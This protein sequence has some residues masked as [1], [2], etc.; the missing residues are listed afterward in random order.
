MY[1]VKTYKSGGEDYD[2]RQRTWALFKCG[3]CNK[4]NVIDIT[5]IK[6]TFDFS[7]ER[8]CE[9]CGMINSEDKILNMKAQLNKL[10]V[11]KSRIQIQIEQ[12][13][14]ELNE[15]TSMKGLVNEKQI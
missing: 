8:R 5:R 4:D 15:A 13:E 6:D 1:F 9:K 2:P 7:C 11:E 12:I 10:T 3:L 14:R